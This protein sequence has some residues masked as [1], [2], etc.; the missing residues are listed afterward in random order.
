[1]VS[2]DAG[3]LRGLGR[4]FLA[5]AFLWAATCTAAHAT[6]INL[7]WRTPLNVVNVGDTVSLGLYAV[8]D[9][10]DVISTA[11]LVFVW[12]PA[13]LELQGIDNSAS[14]ILSSE[15]APSPDNLYGINEAAIPQD[16]DGIYAAFDFGLPLA[17]AG[18]LLTEFV[19]K[20]TA[21]SSPTTVVGLLAQLQKA[22]YGACTSEVTGTVPGLNV[23]GALPAIQL[24]VL[25]EPQMLLL[26]AACF[27]CVLRSRR[28]SRV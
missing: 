17:P 8:P 6:G 24:T 9:G 19:F 26:A 28:S 23:V 2:S 22:G 10:V 7:E 18:T 16:G 12:D 3:F 27:A 11:Q 5:C 1:M 14:T 15:I 25:P 4:S 21:A 13:V 20:A